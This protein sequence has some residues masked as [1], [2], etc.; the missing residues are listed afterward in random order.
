M[1]FVN[2]YQLEDHI[3]DVHVCMCVCACVFVNDDNV[4]L[5]RLTVIT[6]GMLSTMAVDETLVTR[7]I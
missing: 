2:E 3:A 4:L 5:Q 6:P 1:S 7:L